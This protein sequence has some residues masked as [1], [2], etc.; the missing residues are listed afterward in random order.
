M[1]KWYNSVH[2]QSRVAPEKADILAAL[3]AANTS[4]STGVSA[5][6]TYVYF[7]SAGYSPIKIGV[8]DDPKARL[9]K[10]QTAHYKRLKLLFVIECE[11][12]DLAFKIETS[13]HRW[14]AD[15]K[16]VN[17]WFDVHPI[18]IRDDIR[19]LVSLAKSITNVIQHVS[20]KDIEAEEE[21]RVLRTRQSNASARV[22]EYLAV[23]PEAV[24]MTARE[25]ADVI[26]VGK[27]TVADVLKARKR[28]EV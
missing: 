6:A 5:M 2:Q 4:I 19:L 27:T 3:T 11:N 15:V 10:L 17:E 7:I 26:G 1:R 21:R 25:L 22:E 24:S 18:K 20:D 23:N 16:L 8:S 14:Y 13:F 28:N 9:S 12:R